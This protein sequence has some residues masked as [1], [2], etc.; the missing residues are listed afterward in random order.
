MP[1]Q[2]TLIVSV[3]VTTAGTFTPITVSGSG[4]SLGNGITSVSTAST[5]V[6]TFYIPIQYDGSALTNAL[7]FTI[8]SAGSCTADLTKT[9]V[10]AITD[11]W[12]LECLP[13]VGPSLKK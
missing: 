2:T 12:S 4:M 6:R 11:V 3:N 7:Q 9:P 8:G 5:G 1:S 10:K 13:S